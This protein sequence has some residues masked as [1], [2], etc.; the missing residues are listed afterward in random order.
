MAWV[1]GV[2]AVQALVA[3]GSMAADIADVHELA[4]GRRQEGLF[5]GG[6]S[7][8]GKAA[9]GLGH[10][11]AGLWVDL[12]G[13]PGTAAPG[14][15]PGGKLLAFAL[16]YGPGTALIGVLALWV[17]ARFALDRAAVA[18]AQRRLRQRGAAA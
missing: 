6:L 17:F 2:G 10:G 14:A 8:A 5:F 4:T 1:G 15:V 3:A 9:S 13:F 12:L 7:F 18:E 16:V 11:V